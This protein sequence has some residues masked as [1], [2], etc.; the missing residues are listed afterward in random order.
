MMKLAEIYKDFSIIDDWACFLS[1]SHFC[2]IMRVKNANARA[3]YAKDADKALET[4]IAYGSALLSAVK[5]MT[6][7]DAFSHQLVWERS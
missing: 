1:W 6:T 3:F 7:R 4:A 5:I 2:E